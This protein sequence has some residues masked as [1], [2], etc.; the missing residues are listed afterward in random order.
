MKN[1]FTKEEFKKLYENKIELYYE[2]YMD[3]YEYF[4]NY[5]DMGPGT[6][7][8]GDSGYCDDYED[9]IDRLKD[10]LENKIDVNKIEFIKIDYLTTFIKQYQISW[11]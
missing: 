6:L 5:E 3:S 8:S 4:D 9:F 7:I 10:D 2:R 1:L 11:Y